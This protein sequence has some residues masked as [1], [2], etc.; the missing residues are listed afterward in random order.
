MCERVSAREYAEYVKQQVVIR[1][2][3]NMLCIRFSV[4]RMLTPYWPHCPYVNN[5]VMNSVRPAC[6]RLR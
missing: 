2:A 4:A 5:G 3:G 1:S 6:V